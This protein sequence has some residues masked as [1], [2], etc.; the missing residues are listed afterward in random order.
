MKL[1]G[2]SSGVVGL[3]LAV[4]KLGGGADEQSNGKCRIREQ[5]AMKYAKALITGGIVFVTSAPATAQ[6][7]PPASVQGKEYSNNG[8][9]DSLGFV[10]QVQPVAVGCHGGLWVVA[11]SL[12][13]LHQALG[14][15][16]WKGSH[17]HT[18]HHAE[19]GGRGAHPDGQ[20]HDRDQGEQRVAPQAAERV[21]EVECRSG[22]TW[23]SMPP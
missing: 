2:H 17:Q 23:S 7:T 4:E 18:V 5:P 21:A 1:M 9:E 14:L 12:F 19:H 3:T 16:Q 22:D 8:D 6:V 11:L 13:D 20:R 10:A 15:G